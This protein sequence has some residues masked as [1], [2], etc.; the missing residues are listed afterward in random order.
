MKKFI[1][2]LLT[3]ALLLS[4]AVPAM[5]AE[6]DTYYISGSFSGWGAFEPMTWNAA[7]NRYEYV[8][9]NVAATNTGEYQVSS[10]P[11]WQGT[12]YN[13]SGV[14]NDSNNTNAQYTVAEDG[15][16]VTLCFDGTKT[17][18]I[19]TAPGEEAAGP[20][21][22]GEETAGPTITG[23]DKA[24]V[25]ATYTPV[26]TI[27]DIVLS[28]SRNDGCVTVDETNKTYIVTIPAGEPGA[29]VTLT[30][31]GTNLDKAGEYDE[32][33]IRVAGSQ[34][35]VIGSD[36]QNGEYQ[37]YILL[38]PDN[39]GPTDLQYSLDAGASWKNTG[40]KVNVRQGYAVTFSDMI[41]NGTVTA[42]KAFAAEGDTVTLTVTPD[43]GYELDDVAVTYLDAEGN[44]KFVPVTDNTFVMP[45]AEVIV[46]AYFG[47]FTGPYT[48]TVDGSIE[49][50]TISVD[51]TTYTAGERVIV[52]V[53]PNEGYVLDK[54][55]ATVASTGESLTVTY[56]EFVMPAANVN[57]TATFKKGY[58]IEVIF[59]DGGDTVDFPRTAEEGETVTVDFTAME[60]WEL[61][62]LEVFNE[63]SGQLVPHEMVDDNT[64]TFPMPAGKVAIQFYFWKI[65]TDLKTI[66]YKGPW[67][68]MQVYFWND[69]STVSDV[70][71]VPTI[72]E[73]G[74]YAITNIPDHT[75]ELAIK[76]AETNEWIVIEPIPTDGRNMYNAVTG[77]WELYKPS[78]PEVIS[79]TISWGSLAFTYSDEQV[80]LPDG[81]TVDKG[82]S[83]D[84]SD[85]AGTVTVENTGDN[86][87]VASAAYTAA[88]GYTE[89]TGSLDEA[90]TLAANES[91]TFTLTLSGKPNKAL[92]GEPIG[93]VT[94]TIK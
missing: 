57:V 48:V 66:Y 68:N 79:A 36:V 49:G 88:E 35:G 27:S 51:P 89:I 42:D 31:K 21:A 76:N 65:G 90:K 52:D 29:S 71:G 37:C 26:I 58:R 43:E 8:L 33:R 55:I 63:T 4:L 14:T 78:T 87:I 74:I 67:T 17:F 28:A 11:D 83:T 1:S 84:G 22:P 91:G 39:I 59:P 86:A 77:E 40:W 70:I 72:E 25:K 3:L 46:N 75:S 23:G 94:V 19:V 80:T 15:S 47:E 61:R 5:A 32:I 60:G 82:W 10:T 64:F 81:T 41:S 18:A 24:E 6:G 9:T 38:T 16:T 92:H 53:N 45:A 44:W 30:V 2:L 12:R 13:D 73:A 54:V 34:Y 7:Q 93:T 56:T 50:G 85:K 62:L 69:G 20:T